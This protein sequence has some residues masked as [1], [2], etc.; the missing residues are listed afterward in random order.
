MSVPPTVTREQLMERL[1]EAERAVV[2]AGQSHAAALK[3]LQSEG[4]PAMWQ[5]LQEFMAQLS[6]R[7]AEVRALKDALLALDG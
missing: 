1:R 2:E 5:S 3:G 6:Q 7:R 4:Y